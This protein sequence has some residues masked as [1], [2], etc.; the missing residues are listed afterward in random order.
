MPCL[1]HLWEGLLLPR[2]RVAARVW[3]VRV[4][5]RGGRCHRPPPLSPHAPVCTAGSAPARGVSWGAGRG[6]GRRGRRRRRHGLGLDPP[7]HGRRNAASAS[8]TWGPLSTAPRLRPPPRRAWAGCCKQRFCHGGVRCLPCPSLPRAPAWGLG[9]ATLLVL[10]GLHPPP[11]RFHY[12]PPFP[13]ALYCLSLPPSPAAAGPGGSGAGDA[14]DI[15]G[16]DPVGPTSLS[17]GAPR[18]G[19]GVARAHSGVALSFLRFATTTQ[20]GL[21]VVVVVG[22]GVVVAETGRGGG[23][24]AVHTALCWARADRRPPV[25]HVRVWRWRTRCSRRPPAGAAAAGCLT[26]GAP[27]GAGL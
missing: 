20:R 2:T 18:R 14:K 23:G 25:A 26:T 27:S 10:G 15:R 12:H 22:V 21:V 5:S 11:H 13:P 1:L 8:R 7:H 6:G 24:G 4:A 16:G 19:R 3:R 17:P 9:A